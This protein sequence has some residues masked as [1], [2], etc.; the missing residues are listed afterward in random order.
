MAPRWSRQESSS[1]TNAD[2]RLSRWKLLRVLLHTTAEQVEEDQRPLHNPLLDQE[3]GTSPLPWF[4]FAKSWL[5]VQL[6]VLAWASVM[7]SIKDGEVTEGLLTILVLDVDVVMCIQLQVH[8][9]E[10]SDDDGVDVHQHTPIL[11]QAKA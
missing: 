2:W 6:V 5:A 3:R 9:V 10:D 4:W 7:A 11:R 1:S 8:G